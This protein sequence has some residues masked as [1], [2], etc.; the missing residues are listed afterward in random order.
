VEPAGRL[1]FSRR[2][3]VVRAVALIVG[4]PLSRI[5]GNFFLSVNKPSFPVRLST[6]RHRPRLAPDDRRLALM[7]ESAE[8]APSSVPNARYGSRVPRET[9]AADFEKRLEEIVGTIEEFAAL[10]FRLVHRSSGRD[11]VDAVAA[12]VNFLGEELELRSVRSSGGCR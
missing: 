12:G 1:E 9:A 3:D 10:R 4:T 7:S 11:I 5:M 2:E 8:N 6:T